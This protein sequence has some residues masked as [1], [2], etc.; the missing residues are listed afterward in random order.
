MKLYI[1]NTSWLLNEEK[2]REFSL[3]LPFDGNEKISGTNLCKRK[4]EISSGRALLNIALTTEGINI[5]D[6]ELLFLPSG[7]PYVS[8]DIHFSLSHSDNTTTVAT[9]LSDIGFDVQKTTAYNERAARGIMN[10]KEIEYIEKSTDKD[11]AFTRLWSIKEAYAKADGKGLGKWLKEKDFTCVLTDKKE[12]K[13]GDEKWN[14]YT[15]E[16]NGL[17]MAVCHREETVPEIIFC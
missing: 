9:A 7:K 15:T 14:F 16:Y 12:I 11:K 1:M 8:A 13:T 4:V 3:S 17:Y 2:F 5:K 10:E 6:V